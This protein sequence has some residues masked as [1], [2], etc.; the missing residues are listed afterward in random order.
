MQIHQIPG[1]NNDHWGS[2]DQGE[3]DF[4][5]DQEGVFFETD[6]VQNILK[7]CFFL[8]IKLFNSRFNLILW[9]NNGHSSSIAVIN[10]NN[11]TNWDGK[12]VSGHTRTK[13]EKRWLTVYVS[14]N[15][16]FRHRYIYCYWI[17]INDSKFVN[18]EH[19]CH[20]IPKNGT[21]TLHYCWRARVCKFIR[22]KKKNHVS[23]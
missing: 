23:C 21:V 14:L 19:V 8:S 15:K 16:I 20:N 3:G 2:K 7:T 10:H 13:I 1:P 17:V 6:L 18:T 5:E 12:I 9:S 11:R 4:N 22:K